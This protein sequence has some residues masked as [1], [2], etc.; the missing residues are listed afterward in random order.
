MRLRDKHFSEKT[1][2]MSSFDKDWM[3]PELKSL[4]IEMTKEFF[5]NRRSERWKK[6]KR[7]FRK[8]KR[9]AIRGLHCEAF[10][11]RI[12][13]GSK[14]N[15]DKEVRKVGGLKL[16]NKKMFISSLEGMS[17]LQ[18][19]QAIGEEYAV[20][21]QSYSPVDL[22]ALPAFL[23]AQLPPQVT[24]MEV[25]EKIRKQK[26]TKSTFPIDLPDSLRKEFALELTKPL[27]NIYNC[28]LSQGIFPKIWKE[29]LVTP[30]PK[31]SFD[32]NQR[33]KENC[34]FK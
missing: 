15:F 17:D 14:A 12:I 24:E 3:H 8:G 29:E 20:I 7:K 9:R 16:K 4:Y 32:T 11:D 6:L 28:C 34:V 18:C 30:V 10:A 19:A 33:Y 5:N 13:Q 2:K 1:V 26:K 23:P 25:W 21:S 22:S 27:V 31:K